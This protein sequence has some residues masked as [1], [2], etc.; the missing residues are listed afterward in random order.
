[1]SVSEDKVR[2]EIELIASTYDRPSDV[3]AW[4]YQNKDRLQEVNA[5]V[6]E[7]QVVD[8]VLDQAKVTDN[9]V[10]FDEIMKDVR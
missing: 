2:S 10:S 7:D 6:L 9:M 5:M 8:W 1:M 4:Y 3:V